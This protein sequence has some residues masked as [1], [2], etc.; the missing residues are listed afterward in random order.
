LEEIDKENP[1]E[2]KMKYYECDY[3][4]EAS[5]KYLALRLLLHHKDSC[6][7]N[8]MRKK[9]KTTKC[10]QCDF[11]INESVDMKRHMRDIHLVKTDSTSPPPKKKKSVTEELNDKIEEMEAEVS[12]LDDLSFTFEDMEIDTEKD[13]PFDERSRKMDEK[14]L[15]KER[16]NE[17]E[18][19]VLQRKKSSI[20]KKKKK[21]AI[22]NAE[23][24]K[25]MK[26]K[27]KQKIKDDKKKE[28]KRKRV[29]DNSSVGGRK[30]RIPNI[31]EIPEN[32][33]HLV[34]ENDVLYAVPGDGC[35]G[36]NCAAAFL[37]QDEIFG[38]KLRRRMN[39]FFSKHWYKRY[40]YISQEEAKRWRY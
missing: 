29:E 16:R 22:V 11:A 4:V 37:F 23:K 40:Q 9:R 14:I 2:A 24:A 32:C 15:D 35:C 28:K 26:L 38:P 39:M 21:V 19:V 3:E 33:K 7:A 27:Q 10:N 13:E 20:D 18:E 17:E 36:P 5:R 25:Q 30:F 8:K 31:K 1:K 34:K 6:C 12:P